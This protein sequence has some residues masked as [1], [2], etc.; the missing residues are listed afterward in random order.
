[1]RR[2]PTR[3]ER[4]FLEILNSLNRGVLRGR[5]RTQHAIS[6]RWIVD[7][8]FPQIRLAVEVDGSVH[9]GDEQRVLDLEKEQ[10]CARFDITLLRITNA[11]VFGDR[12]LLV[13]KLRDGWRM[14]LKR[15]NKLIGKEYYPARSDRDSRAPRQI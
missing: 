2:H 8:F 11:D 10:D 3:A 7:F 14:A 12:E 4:R 6:G 15:E 5:F 1:M 13:C 9:R